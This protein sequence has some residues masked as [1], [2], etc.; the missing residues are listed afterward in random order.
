MQPAIVNVDALWGRGSTATVDDESGLGVAS[1]SLEMVT[2][3]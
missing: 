1:Q 2:W 3:S